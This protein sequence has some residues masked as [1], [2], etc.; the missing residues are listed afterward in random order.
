MHKF[1]LK[2]NILLEKDEVGRTSAVFCQSLSNNSNS[3]QNLK[4]TMQSLYNYVVLAK[5]KA[6]TDTQIDLLCKIELLTS[7]LY[8]SFFAS[9]LDLPEKSSSS[10]TLKELVYKAIEFSTILIETINIPEE[11]RI[12]NI[13]NLNLQNL[14]NSLPAQK[15][16]TPVPNQNNQ[17]ENHLQPTTTPSEQP[18]PA[19]T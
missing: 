4:E 1:F 7:N 6:T 18:S 17:P 16:Q 10:Q 8:Y 5:E 11:N 9:P 2:H 14:F 3:M 13:I 12:A 19:Q 15:S